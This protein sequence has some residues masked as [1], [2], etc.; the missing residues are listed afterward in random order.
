MFRLVKLKIFQKCQLFAVFERSVLS[1]DDLPLSCEL[2][3]APSFEGRLAKPLIRFSEAEPPTK[4]T[5][6]LTSTFSSGTSPSFN[7]DATDA[8]AF[9][10]TSSNSATYW[11]IS[12][13]FSHFGTPE[14]SFTSTCP[15][16]PGRVL[17]W[18]WR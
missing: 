17:K 9:S 4:A 3:V 8:T 15:L 1:L 2:R 14:P 18:S 10:V 6:V 13:A 16:R 5:D 11:A 12:G 7:C